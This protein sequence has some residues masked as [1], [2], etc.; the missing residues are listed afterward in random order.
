VESGGRAILRAVAIWLN[1]GKRSLTS[2]NGT[3][4]T[5]RGPVSSLKGMI[6]EFEKPE[7]EQVGVKKKAIGLP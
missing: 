5:L 6:G 1:L 3:L 4:K 2:R 7:R